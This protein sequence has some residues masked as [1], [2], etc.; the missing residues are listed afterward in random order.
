VT[1]GSRA[2][3]NRRAQQVYRR[4]REERMKQLEAAA[5]ALEPTR[6]IATDLGVKLKQLAVV[7]MRDSDHRSCFLFLHPIALP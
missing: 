5:A 4:K 2:E 6:R 7:R 3:Q 1:R